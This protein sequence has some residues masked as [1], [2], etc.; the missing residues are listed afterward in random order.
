VRDTSGG[1]EELSEQL[2]VLWRRKWWIVGVLVIT[3]ALAGAR[4]ATQTP[5]YSAS[6]N[7]LLS[8]ASSVD[9]VT[10]QAVVANAKQAQNEADL[11]GSSVVAEA[12]SQQLGY[13][14]AVS[15]SVAPTSDRVTIKA[16]D[17]DPDRAAEIANAFADAYIQVHS[18]QIVDGYTKSV[19]ALQ[20]Q[21]SELQ[22]KISAI[23]DE[24]AGRPSEDRRTIL[25]ADR[26][27]LS[28]QLSSYTE[29]M[30]RLDAAASLA[31][32]SSPKVIDKAT[33]A[34]EPFEPDVRKTLG[35]A[36]AAGL[37]L[38]IGIA[39]LVEYLDDTIKGRNDLESITG[40]PLLAS[41]P[42]VGSRRSTTAP[43]FMDIDPSGAAAEAVRSL[44]TAIQ[45]MSV[46]ERIDTI[47]VTSPNQSE[48]KTTVTA[49]LAIAFAENVG[50]TIV[51]STDLRRPRL[52]EY[53]NVP[54]EPGLTNVLLGEAS[55]PDTVLRL[56]RF[57][58][59]AVVPSGPVPPN[60]AELL[61]GPSAA[62]VIDAIEKAAEIVIFDSPPVLPVS[63]ALV[64]ASRCD[65]TVV[66]VA[67]GRTRRREL[68]TALESLATINAN[69]IGCVLTGAPSGG[70]YGYTYEYKPEAP[71][72]GKKAGSA[73]RLPA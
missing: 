23:D 57:P 40:L 52:H 22:D 56:E 21:I 2:W 32:I 8:N 31:T 61:S 64:L 27:K 18:D 62:K 30:D 35:L 43:V 45:F 19:D 38:G 16:V 33:P 42:S 29:I 72:K 3:V 6:A 4:L 12:A 49:N 54:R 39:F 55:L 44:R 41:V 25:I 10:G 14:A 34:S 24:L 51:V 36:I 68:T 71:K 1:G 65:A 50:R 11:A 58:G 15:V 20:P 47:V 70:H 48:G 60:P 66:V 63:D 5:M 28:D 7:L 53:F 9:P 73:G 59:M 17:E 69:V 13:P 26:S 37:I 46:G 67:Y